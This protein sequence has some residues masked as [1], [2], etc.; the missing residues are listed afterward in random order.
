VNIVPVIFEDHNLVRMRPMTWSLPVF[1]IRC[2]MFNLRERVGLSS[3]RGGGVLLGRTMLKDLHNASGWDWGGASVA[4]P[5]YNGCRFLFLNGMLAPDFAL[6]RGLLA[7]AQDSPDFIWRNEQGLIAALLAG[8]LAGP[9]AAD[10]VAWEQENARQGV[11][12]DPAQT[13][14]AWRGPDLLSS[15]N[16]LRLE[17]G[18]EILVDRAASGAANDLVTKLQ[19]LE[20][21]QARAPGWIWDIVHCTGN[22]LTDDLAFVSGGVSFRRE[23]FG[24]FPDSDNSAPDWSQATTFDTLASR[25]PADLVSR[26]AIDSSDRVYCGEGVELAPGTAVNTASG[27]VILDRGVR[28]MPHCYLEGPLYVGPGSL[29]KP[30]ARILGE[31]SFGIV[32][33][34]AGE[35]GEST[36]GDFANKQHEGFIGHA[37]LGSWINLGAMTTCSDLKNNY[38]E[39]RVDLGSGAVA[40][41]R[42]FVGLM[43]GDHAKT[44]IGA[45]FNTGTCVGFA[46]NIFGAG[47]PPK[48]V[49][50][51]QWGGQAGCPRYAVD[52]AMATAKIV[53]SR[54]GCRFTSAQGELFVSLGG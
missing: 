31:S 29:V 1:E 24:V 10:W 48:F 5:E 2:G 4:V 53:M 41:G 25:V 34:L 27:P 12:K 13:P 44:A 30:G 40:T 22:A 51:F 23:P 42:R 43:M 54:R 3:D 14:R 6:V 21:L 47:M 11:W 16:P 33:R 35:I 7:L 32:N 15:E 8:D 39:I 18:G 17:G 36:F 19:E 26:M 52:R 49:D 46:S 20:K 45:L 38:G 50:N 9:A 28:V 37:V